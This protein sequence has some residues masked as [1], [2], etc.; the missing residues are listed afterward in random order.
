MTFAGTRHRFLMVPDAPAVRTLIV[1]K[2]RAWIEPLAIVLVAGVA[3]YVWFSFHARADG[4]HFLEF[5][6][7]RRNN[8]TVLR[9]LNS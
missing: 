4:E 2:K 1:M 6:G 5:G 9:D 8:Q 3:G 7:Y